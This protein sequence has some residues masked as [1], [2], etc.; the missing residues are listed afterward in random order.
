MDF[1]TDR[2]PGDETDFIP[3][4][5][6]DPALVEFSFRVKRHECKIHT[7]R[8]GRTVCAYCGNEMEL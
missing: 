8:D 5:S 6:P 7:I 4:V 1:I 2:D 3:P